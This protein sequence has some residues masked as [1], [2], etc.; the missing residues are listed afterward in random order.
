[1]KALEWLGFA[2]GLLLVL[3][4]WGSVLETT[5]VPRGNRSGLSALILHLVNLP[6]RVIASR[7]HDFEARDR[8]LAYAAAGDLVSTLLV[9]LL[10]FFVGYALMLWPSALDLG[11]AFRTAGSSMLTLGIA[12]PHG[13]VSTAVVYLAAL[14]GLVVIALQIAYLPVLYSAY[15]RR[16]TLVTMLEGLAGTPGWGPMILVRSAAVDNLDGLGDMYDRWMQ[17]AADVAESH[18]AYVVLMYFRS[19]TARRSWVISLLSILDA[20]AM[21]LALCPISAPGPARNLMRIGYLAFRQL[22]ATMGEPVNHDPSPDDDIQL[23]FEEFFMA[24]ERLR[25]S[26][27]EFEREPEQA[28]PHFKGWRVNYEA[29]AYA[30]AA[31]LDVVPA[32]WSGPRLR[33]GPPLPPMAPVDRVSLGVEVAEVRRIGALRRQRRAELQRAGQAQDDRSPHEQDPDS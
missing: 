11:D 18:S 3:A 13:S 20:A 12:A 16:E 9:W 23:Q 2:A 21:H 7:V 5:I 15:N 30:L 26:G 27:M 32:L 19:P 8:L 1:M 31:D 33:P 25:S 28:W 14:T 4:T 22:A 29:A 10:L 17:W 6:V 24:C